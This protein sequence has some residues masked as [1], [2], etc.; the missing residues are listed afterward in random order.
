MSESDAEV[1]LQA[2][3]VTHRFTGI[4][5]ASLRIWHTRRVNYTFYSQVYEVF[6][7]RENLCCLTPRTPFV[8][9]PSA[10][11]LFVPIGC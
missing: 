6:R 4:D 3:P 11:Y 7:L 5:V 9:A 1:Q 8:V 2:T 10:H